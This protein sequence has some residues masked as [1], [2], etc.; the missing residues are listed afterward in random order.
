MV[1]EE[2]RLT[3][4]GIGGGVYQEKNNEGETLWKGHVLIDLTD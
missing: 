3:C 1:N 4:E 2:S